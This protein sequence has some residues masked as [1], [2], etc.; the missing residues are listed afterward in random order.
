MSRALKADSNNNEEVRAQPIEDELYDPLT[1]AD[2]FF[3]QER[4]FLQENSRA[5]LPFHCRHG[6]TAAAHRRVPATAVGEQTHLVAW[7][8]RGL[9]LPPS[10]H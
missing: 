3:F 8:W 5:I 10:G 1:T 9:A 2:V 6:P 7:T 4:V